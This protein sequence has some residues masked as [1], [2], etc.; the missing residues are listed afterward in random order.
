MGS[1]DAFEYYYRSYDE[2]EST[3]RK[4]ANIRV[5][6]DAMTDKRQGGPCI[7][8]LSVLSFI[9]FTTSIVFIVLCIIADNILIIHEGVDYGTDLSCS[10]AFR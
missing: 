5:R 4:Q 10:F 9:F 2:G 1:D 8:F 6:V 3:Y 7:M